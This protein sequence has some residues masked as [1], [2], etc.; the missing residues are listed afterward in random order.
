MGTGSQ[1]TVDALVAEVSKLELSANRAMVA[2]ERIQL[3]AK[4]FLR[5]TW[6]IMT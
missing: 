6:Q 4:V 5:E 1:E 2:M 3:E